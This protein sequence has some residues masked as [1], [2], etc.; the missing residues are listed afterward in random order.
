[1]LVTITERSAMTGVDTSSCTRSPD[2]ST[3]SHV[4]GPTDSQ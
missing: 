2:R 4:T 1:M 3:P